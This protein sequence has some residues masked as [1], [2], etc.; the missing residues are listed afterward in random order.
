MSLNPATL[1]KKQQESVSAKDYQWMLLKKNK[2]FLVSSL[3]LPLFPFLF[4][5]DWEEEESKHT[6][7][8]CQVR[9]VLDDQKWD[10]LCEEKERPA[11]AAP[12]GR[13]GGGI[14]IGWSNRIWWI[15]QIRGLSYLFIFLEEGGRGRDIQ[16][17]RVKGTR[18]REKKPRER[19]VFSRHSYLLLSQ[20]SSCFLVHPFLYWFIFLSSS[21]SNFSTTHVH[22]CSILS[23]TIN[24]SPLRPP[25]AAS[26]SSHTPSFIVLLFL[27]LFFFLFPPPCFPESGVP[28][29]G[30]EK[31]PAK[32][33]STQIPMLPLA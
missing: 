31:C 15:C 19:D 5:R 3:P 32:L 10:K 2:A 14:R 27:S 7:P 6:C 16:T 22:I 33:A 25:S 28:V 13:G 26:F 24:L 9:L 29:R 23:L 30:T 11:A 18:A 8:R 4:L 12:G 17:D 1:R 21:C 20:P